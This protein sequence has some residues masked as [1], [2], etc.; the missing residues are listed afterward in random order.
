MAYQFQNPS[1]DVI[2]D[3]VKRAKTIAI[4]GLSA[5]KETAAYDVAQVLQSAGDKIIP[6]NPRAVG[7]E[8]LG[9][10]VYARLQDI[11]EHIDI[12]DVFRRSDFLADV[13]RDFIETD[14]DVFWA[15]LG[16]QSQEAEKILRFAGCDQIVMNKCLKIEYLKLN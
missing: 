13:A 5:R 12:V 6:V 16:L 7:D 2:F 10:T 4:V 8:I 15:Q 9:E 1:Q 3:Y 11:P 14:A